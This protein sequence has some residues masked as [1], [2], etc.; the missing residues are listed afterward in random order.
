MGNKLI[1]EEKGKK[2]LKIR[3]LSFDKLFGF[4]VTVLIFG[5]YI[6]ALYKYNNHTPLPDSSKTIYYILIG[7]SFLIGL[8]AFSK[9]TN[10]TLVKYA[11]CPY[12]NKSTLLIDTWQCYWCNSI[13]P[14]PTSFKSPCGECGRLQETAYCEHCKAEFIL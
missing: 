14:K 1:G 4:G 5:A 8:L 9:L 3:I 11:K 7:A 13:Q 10:P 2:L 6:Y 12:C